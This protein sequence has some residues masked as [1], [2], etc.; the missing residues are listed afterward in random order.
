MISVIQEKQKSLFQIFAEKIEYAGLKYDA[1]ILRIV[2]T[3][4]QTRN[5]VKEFI[6]KND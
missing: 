4:E 5:E 3:I 2:V 6:G 1:R